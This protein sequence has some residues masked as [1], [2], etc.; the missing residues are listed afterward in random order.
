MRDLI[1]PKTSLDASV[2]NES[3]SGTV[4]VEFTGNIRRLT[5]TGDTTLSPTGTFFP[6]DVIQL[7]MTGDPALLKVDSTTYTYL[8]KPD[9]NID[10]SDVVLNYNGLRQNKVYLQYEDTNT[11]SITVSQL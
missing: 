4:S 8:G 7:I 10:A 3:V 1:N 9:G 2:T 6:G 11:F 5:L